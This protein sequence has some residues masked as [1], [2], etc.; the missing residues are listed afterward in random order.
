MVRWAASTLAVSIMSSTNTLAAATNCGSSMGSCITAM[1]RV[2][3][4]NANLQFCA[5]VVGYSTSTLR[6]DVRLER[7]GNPTYSFQTFRNFKNFQS[8]NVQL[9]PWFYNHKSIFSYWFRISY[10]SADVRVINVYVY[11]AMMFTTTFRW[12]I[13]RCMGSG[14]YAPLISWSTKYTI[15]V[16]SVEN[17]TA[18]ADYV[19]RRGLEITQEIINI[20]QFAEK[21]RIGSPGRWEL[22]SFSVGAAPFK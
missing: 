5:S 13:P 12:Y 2:P 1:A 17:S 6:L 14:V 19:T 8:A 11:L 21:W 22:E 16:Q 3:R 4:L 18:S 9:P 10:N 15:H 20:K 7:F